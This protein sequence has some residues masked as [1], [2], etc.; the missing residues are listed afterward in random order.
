MNW[1]ELKK[2]NYKNYTYRILGYYMTNYTTKFRDAEYKDNIGTKVEIINPS[3]E[4]VHSI[5]WM[6]YSDRH[7]ET[8]HY[9]Y[10]IRFRTINKAKWYDMFP[11]PVDII[12]IEDDYHR[13]LSDWTKYCEGKIDKLITKS[14][15]EKYEREITD[16]L[17]DSVF[18][19]YLNR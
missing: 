19:K 3:G 17:P 12:H 14:E 2:V 7:S 9:Q 6:E 18:V 13:V 15:R 1:K 5:N 10:L 4:V 16:G 8:S 11:K